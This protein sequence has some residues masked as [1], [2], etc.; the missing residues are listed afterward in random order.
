MTGLDW[1]IVL[2]TALLAFSGYMRG[3]IVAVLSLAG[4][5]AGAV[6]GTRIAESLLSGGASSPYAPVFGLFGA[7]LAGGILAG[8]LET[9][10]LRLRS[11]VPWPAL[12]I[13]DGLGGGLFSAAVA[14]GVVWVL[15]TV[16]IALP[17]ASGLRGSVE[18]SVILRR[19]DE[20]L[21]SGTLLNFIARIDPLPT[22]AG[23]TTLVPPPHA[24]ILRA[25]RIRAARRSVV[26]ILGSACGIDLEGSGFLVAPGEVLTNAHVV[27]GETDT[28]VEVAGKPPQLPATVVLFDPRDDL[29]IL[30]VA[31]LHLRSLPL[32][33]APPAGEAGAILGYPEDGPFVAEPG[34]IGSTQGVETEDAYGRGPILRDLTPVRGLV[35]PGNSGGPVV[36]R[37]GRVLTTIFAATTS[38]PAGGYGIANATVRAA[39][40]RVGGPTSTE[41]C[42]S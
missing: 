2:V 15:G 27:A 12:R 23:P 22:I 9:V 24:A 34:R 1:L 4:F 32:A 8:G 26:R 13:L 40:A 37:A 17:G 19:L 5:V 7:L 29:A 20:L 42:I 36:D 21:P 41:G 30:R 28:S 3:L 35:R 31:G 6:I 33:S 18:R 38:G 16:I 11:A 14:L 10:G 39:L 25:A